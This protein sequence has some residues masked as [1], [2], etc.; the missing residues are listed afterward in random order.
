MLLRIGREISVG[1][2]LC[3]APEGP[4]PGKRYPTLISRPILNELSRD[5][6]CA[7]WR[8]HTDFLNGCSS[9]PS[10][11]C[12]SD[13][14]GPKGGVAIGAGKAPGSTGLGFVMLAPY[15]IVNGENQAGT[16]EPENLSIRATSKRG[17]INRTRVLVRTCRK[18]C[19]RASSVTASLRLIGYAKDVGRCVNQSHAH[20]FLIRG[21][22]RYPRRQSVR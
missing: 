13:G 3:E 8:H 12:S 9:L 1:Y 21:S 22:H 19:N 16:T 17:C 10:L 6:N 11:W 2:L 20:V 14:E 5:R 15:R 7:V 18:T 4:V